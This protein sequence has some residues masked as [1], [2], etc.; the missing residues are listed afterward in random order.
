MDREEVKGGAEKLGGKVKEQ[1]GKVTGRPA[2]EQKGRHEQ[3]EGQV[4]ENVGKTRDAI[5]DA[6]K[7]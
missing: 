6:V 1:F 3:A 4:R 2:T 7:H 5:K